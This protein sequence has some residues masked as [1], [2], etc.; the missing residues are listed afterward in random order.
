MKVLTETVSTLASVSMRTV[1][2]S[3]GVGIV[4][5]TPNPDFEWP[6][7]EFCNKRFGAAAYYWTANTDELGRIRFHDTCG[8]KKGLM[9]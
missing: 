8:R 9:R 1:L 6:A 5:R 4:G 7:C 2:V 3:N